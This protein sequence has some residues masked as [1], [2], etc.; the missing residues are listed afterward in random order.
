MAN[1]NSANLH[2][3]NNDIAPYAASHTIPKQV[4]SR[5]TYENVITV[6]Y[7]TLDEVKW[8]RGSARWLQYLPGIPIAIQNFVF[9]KTS[10][11]HL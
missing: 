3:R 5:V 6:T 2:T 8:V 10:W 1:K 11:G 4:P 9:L 7:H